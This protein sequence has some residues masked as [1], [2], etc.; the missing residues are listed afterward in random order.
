MLLFCASH[1]ACSQ[2]HN[3]QWGF[4]T[5]TYLARLQFWGFS[6]LSKRYIFTTCLAMTQACRVRLSQAQNV[7]ATTNWHHFGNTLMTH[8]VWL[9]WTRTERPPKWKPKTV[10]SPVLGK[11]SVDWDKTVFWKVC[12]FTLP[13]HVISGRINNWRNFPFYRRNLGTRPSYLAALKRAD[14]SLLATARAT[15]ESRGWELP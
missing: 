13:S 9:S 2:E 10:S 11:Y 1:A 6:I 14:V 8:L 5:S 3:K 7:N 4:C 15:W 12:H